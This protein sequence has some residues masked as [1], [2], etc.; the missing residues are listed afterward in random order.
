MH[1]AANSPPKNRHPGSPT[2]PRFLDPAARF[3]PTSTR[4]K[5]S[6]HW[7]NGAHGIHQT[8]PR[9]RPSAWD[10][11]KSAAAGSPPSQIGSA[12][13]VPPHFQT[14][15]GSPPLRPA[16]SCAP[17]PRAWPTTEPPNAAAA[18]PPHRPKPARHRSGSA[19]P[20]STYPSRSAHSA[21]RAP[22]SPNQQ[23]F[24]PQRNEWAALNGN[25]GWAHIKQ[26]SPYASPQRK[27]CSVTSGIQF[28]RTGNPDEPVPRLV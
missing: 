7:S 26:C 9:R 17:A 25:Q 8:P 3:A 20:A 2:S 14:V 19:A 15:F 12:C 23:R 11:V 1:K 22:K 16:Y 24:D 21:P 27:T 10:L 5:Y 13:S 18:A 4:K 28:S 6:D